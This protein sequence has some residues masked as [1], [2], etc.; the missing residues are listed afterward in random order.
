VVIII[1]PLEA[2]DPYIAVA[3][4]SLRTETD[5]M[6]LGFTK[7]RKLELPDTFPL[8]IGI[9]SMM[10][11]GSFEAFRDEPP[12]ILIVA[13]EPGAPPEVLITTPG[14][15]PTSNSWGEVIAPWL[16]SL[17]LTLATEPVASDFFTL[18]YPITT[19][20]STSSDEGARSIL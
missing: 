17:E 8:E 3:E 18:P 13:P 4:A 2:R 19:S 9:P 1:T 6:S 11:R 15:L 14:V 5:S 10:I 20:S 12:R 7:E 16:K